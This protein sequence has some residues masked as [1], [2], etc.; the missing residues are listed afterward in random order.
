MNNTE[1]KGRYFHISFY[2]KDFKYLFSKY[3]LVAS[4]YDRNMDLHFLRYGIEFDVKILYN[5]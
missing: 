1:T 5:I 2:K 3:Y 4:K